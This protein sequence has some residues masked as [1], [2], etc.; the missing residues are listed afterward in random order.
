[1]WY[2]MA[3][4]ED[5]VIMNMEMYEETM[6]MNHVISKLSEAEEQFKSGKFM[7]AKESLRILGDKYC[8]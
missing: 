1:M 2:N 4:K 3:T 6:F 8:V 5:M 7:D